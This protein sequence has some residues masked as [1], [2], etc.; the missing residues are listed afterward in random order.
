[1]PESARVEQEKRMINFLK[2]EHLMV[3][4]TINKEGAPESAVVGYT[5]T[6]NLEIIFC[7]FNTTRKYANLK[8]NPHVSLVIGWDVD[9]KIT[10]QYEG[11][12][13]EVIDTNEL[14]KHK[15]LHIAKRPKREKHVYDSRERCFKVKPKWIRYSH[16]SKDPEEI[17]ELRF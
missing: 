1:M 11:V 9:E 4:S 2:R 13:E 16:L 12:A 6:P 7:T 10:I 8:K 3:I 14:D 15:K 5:E 17:F